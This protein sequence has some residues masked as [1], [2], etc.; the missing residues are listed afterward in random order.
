MKF[1]F[2]ILFLFLIFSSCQKDLTCSDFKEG[3]F[4]MNTD[5]K[6]YTIVR[7]GN[8]QVE[9]IKNIKEGINSDSIHVTLQWADDCTYRLKYDNSKMT[10]GNRE[11]V[12]NEN[13]GI[14]VS[15]IGINGK[16]MDYNAVMTTNEGEI[17]EQKGSICK[18]F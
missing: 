5:N 2:K 13:N 6:N 11:R 17:I 9:Y 18:E 10:F 16:C 4:S 14:V 7:S 15:V 12:V 8:S 1:C 3:T